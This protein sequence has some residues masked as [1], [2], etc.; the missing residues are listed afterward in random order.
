MPGALLLAMFEAAAINEYR[1]VK[2]AEC[3]PY[4]FTTRVVFVC[5]IS[6]TV[7]FVRS[8]S[9]RGSRVLMPPR[10]WTIVLSRIDRPGHRSSAGA[11]PLA[12]ALEKDRSKRGGAAPA[13]V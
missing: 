8:I 2:S 5:S 3:G 6:S 4:V 7:V 11:P 9:T 12:V 10:P 1:S 13:L